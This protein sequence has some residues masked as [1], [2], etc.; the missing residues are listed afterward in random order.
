MMQTRRGDPSAERFAI[1][2][3]SV[4][5]LSAANRPLLIILDDAQW[6]DTATLRLTAF[7]AG[8]LRSMPV[9]LVVT[10]RSNEPESAA[11]LDCLSEM[12][13]APGS[14]RIALHGLPLPA[15]QQ[16]LA[17]SAL[18]FPT[19]TTA[20]LVHDRTAGNPLFVRELVAL[21]ASETELAH[22]AA[23]T[24]AV[25]D[26]VQDVIRRRIGRLPAVTQQ[27][28]VTAAVVGRQFALDVLAD[29]AGMELGQVLDD[30]DPAFA[31]GVLEEDAAGVARMQ[32]THALFAETLAAELSPA[33]RARLHAAVV[34]AVERLR[35]GYLDAH[36]TMLAY[37]AASGAAMGTADKAYEYAVAAAKQATAQVADEEAGRLWE[38]ALAALE[39]VRPGDREARFYALLE[40]GTARN[41]AGDV[42]GARD[43]LVTAAELAI[44]ADE[45][46]ALVQALLPLEQPGLW[47][48]T[49]YGT[50]DP[51]LVDALRRAV[52]DSYDDLSPERVRLLGM[53]ATN[54]LHAGDAATMRDLGERAVAAARRHEDPALIGTALMRRWT[55]LGLEQY[56]ERQAVADEVVALDREHGL[57]ADIRA[58]GY[59]MAGLAAMDRLDV[60]GAEEAM[61]MARAAAERCGRPAI[62]TEVGWFEA[63]VHL[64]RGRSQ[65]AEA[66]AVAT[67]DLYRRTRSLNADTILAGILLGARADHGGLDHL[68]EMTS[69]L[70]RNGVYTAVARA[71]MAWAGAEGGHEDLARKVV[72]SPADLARTTPDYLQRATFVGTAYAWWH[73]GIHADAAA[74]LAERLRPWS[75]RVAFPGSTGPFLGPVTLALARL[76]DLAGDPAE[77]RHWIAETVATCERG[78]PTWLARALT[79]QA[80]WLARSPEPADQAAVGAVRDRAVAAARASGCVPA[81]RRL[82]IA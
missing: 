68:L 34:A 36:L 63:L 80:E 16:W 50:V 39:L 5:A 25:P 44:A 82:G 46:D 81:L 30:L 70:A 26:A 77:A 45:D 58:S 40:M 20:A 55:T 10:V 17:Q 35:A 65:E 52:G 2:A 33:R 19:P 24:R 53:L 64:A 32:F 11:L 4:T 71:C 37:H 21:M 66:R 47:P 9:L 59:L 8:E 41:R 7:V 22:S 1:H 62:V 38:R 67:Y 28:L 3:A 73:L 27:L 18:Q 56:A 23:R 14:L 29:V 6:A 42:T 74:P 69:S 78:Y 60:M 15:V 61:E 72:L 79:D 76:A 12:A 57:P 75:D 51:H 31:A 48:I 49:D 13:R 43:A 54:L